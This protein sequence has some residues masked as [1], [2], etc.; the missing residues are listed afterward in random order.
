MYIKCSSN[1]HIHIYF[2][3]NMH[4]NSNAKETCW[5]ARIYCVY[6]GSVK[7]IYIKVYEQM[8]DLSKNVP[9][10]DLSIGKVLKINT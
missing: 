3:L 9:L 1:S 10:S 2:V 7:V 8:L 6:V 5:I 4:N